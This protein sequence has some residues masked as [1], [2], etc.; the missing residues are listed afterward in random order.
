MPSPAPFDRIEDNLSRVLLG[1]ADTIREVLAALVAGGHVLVEDVPG[2]GKTSLAR[3]L[4]ASLDAT[5][6]RIQFTPDL[7]PADLT[8]TSVPEGREG[9]LV[10]R[11]GPVFTQV[12]LADELNRATPRTQS[13][14]LEC[15]EERTTTVEGAT[16]ALDP[17]F[18]VIATQNPVEQHGVYPLPEAQLDRFMIRVSLG[19]PTAAEE[20]RLIED[21]RGA[22][23]LDSL[24]PVGSPAQV[25][26]ARS[27][28]GESIAVAQDVTE[29]AVKIVGE[30]R[31]HKDVVLGGSPRASLALV[32]MS[33]ALAWLS[34]RPYA[35]PDDVKRLVPTVLRH[36][37]LLRPQARLAGR[38]PD[39]VLREILDR[40]E[41]PVESYKRK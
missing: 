37:V 17:F 18:F 30:T 26:E 12:L 28:L 29:Y 22:D 34:G 38:T 32:R 11:P 41:A 35:T 4:A 2:V 19:Y 5:F 40:V 23:P 7:L 39:L 9:A 10:F 8:G 21:R 24:K 36:R 14:L 3:A 16:R 25:L 1:K 15:M 31:R 13:A 6:R 20:A 27:Q 33:R